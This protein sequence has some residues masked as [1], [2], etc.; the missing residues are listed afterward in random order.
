MMTPIV[1]EFTDLVRSVSL[2]PPQIPYLS[3]VTG[4]WITPEQATDP[5]YWAQHLCQ[6]VRF[7]AG[8]AELLADKQQL[9]IEIGPG[10]SLSS[11]AKQHPD[12]AREQIPQ[13]LPTLPYVYNGQSDMAFLLTTLGKV[14]LQGQ[15]VDWAGFYGTERHQRIPLPTYPFEHQRYW[16]DPPKGSNNLFPLEPED[17]GKK[18][19]AAD[20]FYEPIWEASPLPASTT[21][22]DGRWLIFADS[23]GWGT[24]LAQQLDQQGAAVACVRP[25][26]GYAVAEDGTFT[27]RPDS[28]DDY[29]E[30]LTALKEASEWPDHI[31]HAWGIS[32][33]DTQDSTLELFAAEQQVGF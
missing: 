18:T 13:I 31:I 2:H 4:E 33:A 29:R 7:G 5:T 15:P 8:L 20:W 24:A 16:I 11:F 19:N 32:Q 28:Q 30:L 10:Q 6:T 23:L 12:C 3:N 25:G 14:W 26:A 17:K 22:A 1:E 21:G 27:V 9:L